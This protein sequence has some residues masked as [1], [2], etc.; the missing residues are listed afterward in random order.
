MMVWSARGTTGLTALILCLGMTTS[1]PAEVQLSLY[2]GPQSAPNGTVRD[3]VLGEGQVHW[4]GRSFAAPPHYGLRATWWR[5]DDWGFG[6]EINHAKVYAANKAALGYDVLEFSDGLNLITANALRRFPTGGLWTPYV[7]G[8]VGIAVPHVEV[9]RSGEGRTLGYQV[10]GPAV[11]VM[12]GASYEISEDWSFFAEY[13]GSY[14]SNTA[15]VEAGGT[16]RTEIVTNALN[17]GFSYDF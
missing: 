12:L 17:L 6:A 10:T 13:K 8:G 9:Q 11:S 1:A 4:Q 16:L 3:S 5:S 2:A 15:R 14:S 7:G